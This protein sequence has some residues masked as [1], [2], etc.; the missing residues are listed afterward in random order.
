MDSESPHPPVTGPSSQEV[1]WPVTGLRQRSSCAYSKPS[2]ESICVLAP[3]GYSLV[4]T[5]Q[6]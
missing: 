6:N 5:L 3:S 2:A 4:L 1:G